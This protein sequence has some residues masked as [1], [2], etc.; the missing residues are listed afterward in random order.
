MGD[1][2]L[3]AV[4]DGDERFG[5]SGGELSQTFTGLSLIIFIAYINI[6][7]IIYY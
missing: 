3:V 1:G 7:H 5:D 6:S 2:D 4:I